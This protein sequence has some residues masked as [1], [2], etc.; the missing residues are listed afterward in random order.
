MYK[1]VLD[2]EDQ[3]ITYKIEVRR[4]LRPINGGTKGFVDEVQIEYVYKDKSK[5]VLDKDLKG[6]Q[7]TDSKGVTF[8]I[9]TVKISDFGLKTININVLNKE[10]QL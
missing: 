3:K 7:Q 4:E 9:K 1:N 6:S 5:Y 10:L 8:A 2:I